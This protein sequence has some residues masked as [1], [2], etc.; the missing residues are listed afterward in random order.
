MLWM[1][2]MV[3]QLPSSSVAEYCTAYIAPRA[4][5]NHWNLWDEGHIDDFFDRLIEDCVLLDGGNP[6]NV[7]LMGYSAGGNGA[8]QL[9]PRLAE[10][11]AAA[12]TT[13]GHPSNASPLGLRN[14]PFAIFAGAEDAAYQR[15]TMTAEWGGKLDALARQNPGAYP[16]RL[17]VYPGLGHWMNGKDAEAVPWMAKFT[18]NPWPRKIVWYQSDRLHDRFYRL[19]LPEG[20]AKPGLTIH[21]SVEHN[22]ITL[23]APDVTCVILRLHDRLEDLDQPLKVLLNGKTVFEGKVPR[24]A[25]AI[26]KSLQQRADPHS[27]A[28]ALLEVRAKGSETAVSADHATLQHFRMA[29]REHCRTKTKIRVHG[30]SGDNPA[31]AVV[32]DFGRCLW[33]GNPFPGPHSLRIAPVSLTQHGPIAR[34]YPDIP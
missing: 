19:A 20:V 17:N 5:T 21:T 10:R 34:K 6:D 23:D 2:A 12:S 18:R 24:Q 1:V 3:V 16:H 33:P 29:R 25:D 31:D 7:Y 22:V 15:N 27:A 32:V 30:P 8:Y 26:L 14:L 11:F 9:A 28:T 13:T 4:P